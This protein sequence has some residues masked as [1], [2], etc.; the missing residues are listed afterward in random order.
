MSV[1][2]DVMNDGIVE[3]VVTDDISMPSVKVELK[4]SVLIIV[5]G[6]AVV[7]IT[8]RPSRIVRVLDIVFNEGS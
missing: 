8:W 1:E 6:G 3:V 4:T 2:I 7:G 5:V